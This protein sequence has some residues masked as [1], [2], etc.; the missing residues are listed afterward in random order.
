MA[1]KSNGKP[2]RPAEK[3]AA[4][5]REAKAVAEGKVEPARTTEKRTLLGPEWELVA[6]TEFGPPPGGDGT[7]GTSAVAAHRL[8][9]PG[10]WLYQTCARLNGIGSWQVSTVFV[11]APPAVFLNPVVVG[12][13]R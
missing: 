4:G 5:L 2:A 3:I 11:P 6:Y 10:G 12:P 1:T 7:M 9:V 13:A 8:A